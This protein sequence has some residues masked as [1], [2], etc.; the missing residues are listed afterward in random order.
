MCAAK[1]DMVTI[2]FGN[3]FDKGHAPTELPL[4]KIT[5]QGTTG[6]HLP[7]QLWPAQV[8]ISSLELRML[9]SRVASWSGSGGITTVYVTLG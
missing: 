2:A 5:L 6:N 8:A 7:L 3:V 4:T 9:L 1:C